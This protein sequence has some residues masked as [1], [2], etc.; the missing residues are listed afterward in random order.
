MILI[1]REKLEY[2]R[3][4]LH[5]SSILQSSLVREENQQMI[6]EILVRLKIS[7]QTRYASKPRGKKTIK[8]KP[9]RGINCAPEI[10]T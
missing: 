9:S 6:A 8:T 5:L 10:K 3:R 2:F 7:R 1:L 4:N